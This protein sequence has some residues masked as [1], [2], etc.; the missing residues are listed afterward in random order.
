MIENIDTRFSATTLSTETSDTLQ[1]LTAEKI[2]AALASPTPLARQIKQSAASIPEGVHDENLKILDQ[3][4]KAASVDLSTP[5]EII[6]VV[7][8]IRE[9]NPS[10]TFLLV[11]YE[12]VI[13]AWCTQRVSHRQWL[14]KFLLSPAQ[15]LN[16]DRTKLEE[17]QINS[18]R[19]AYQRLAKTTESIKAINSF[20]EKDSESTALIDPGVFASL[21]SCMVTFNGRM[22]TCYS[23]ASPPEQKPNII[24]LANRAIH[25]PEP[26]FDQLPYTQIEDVSDPFGTGQEDVPD[27]YSNDKTT[28]EPPDTPNS[29]EVM[30]FLN[31]LRNR[32]RVPSIV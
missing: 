21:R 2:I 3:A 22:T 29:K 7:M 12:K 27:G 30:E 28:S 24:P 6:S 5:E 17:G 13:L 25:L 8:S 16:T 9:L 15:A 4:I 14:T 11:A 32:P 10:E 26:S 19:A 18:L 20:P 23:I 31:S 1:P